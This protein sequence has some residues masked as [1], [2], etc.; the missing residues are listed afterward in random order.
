[1]DLEVF[2]TKVAEL[3]DRIVDNEESHF[4]D[5]IY[6][7]LELEEGSTFIDVWDDNVEYSYWIDIGCDLRKFMME[8][9]SLN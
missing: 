4:L 9:Y 3:K 8:N 1:M 6:D 7:D 5:Y 2:K